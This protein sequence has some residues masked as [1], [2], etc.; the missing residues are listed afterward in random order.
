MGDTDRPG[1]SARTRFVPVAEFRRL[2]AAPALRGARRR[3]FAALARINTLYMIAGAWSGHIGTS[4]S[5]LEI[6]SWLFLQRDARSRQGRDGVRH[7]L[8][9]EGA[10]RAGALRGADR[11][12]PAAGREAAPAAAAARAAGPPARRDAV[13]PGQ[14]RLARHGHLQGEGD[15]ARQPAGRPAAPHLRADRRRRAAGRAVLGVAAVGGDARPRRDRRRSSITTRS[16]RTPGSHEVSRL[17]DLEA[18]LRAFGWHV[19]RVRRPRRGRARA[20]VPRARRRDRSA[21][22]DH[23][24]HG[25]GQGRQLHGRAGGDEGRR[26]LPLSLGRARPNASTTAALGGAAGHGRTRCSP[27]S[28]SARWPPSRASRNPRREPRQT[29]NL[30]AAYEQALVAPANGSPTLLALDADLVK[31]CG[32]V[33]FAKRFPER[34]VECGIA[35]QDMVSMA[36]GM[37]RRGALP[38]VHSFACFLAARPNE[39]IYNQCS[40][41]SKVIYVGSLAG[42]LPG[43]PGHSHQSVRDISAL[44]AVPDLVMAEPTAEAEVAPLLDALVD[45]AGSALPASRVGEVAGAVRLSGR[46]PRRGG[47]GLDGSRGRRRRRLRLRTMA[48]VERLARGGRRS[49]PHGR[50]P[51]VVVNCR[52]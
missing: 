36:C 34:F 7:L 24:R 19:S 1:R 21:E 52:G 39:Q 25:Q 30:V 22:G 13:R 45:G 4:F 40:E 32:L 8:L 49:R 27:S 14:H 44:A 28:A 18:K 16:S 35:E 15:G 51:A 31:D 42:L 47:A 20:H 12:R 23:R 17:G 2:L 9:V 5:S 11:P 38:I 10:R 46:P 33:S 6:M 3:A 50:A 29:D 41:S 26:A 48:A 37:A 43:G